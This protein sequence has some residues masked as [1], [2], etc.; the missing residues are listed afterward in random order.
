MKSNEMWSIGS[1]AVKQKA[2][3]WGNI[4]PDLCHHMESLDHNMYVQVLDITQFWI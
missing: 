1:G 4:D 3:T 2:I